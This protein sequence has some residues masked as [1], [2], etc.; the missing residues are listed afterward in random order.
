[1]SAKHAAPSHHFSIDLHI[2]TNRGSADSELTPADLIERAREL[3][4]DAVCITEHDAM[5]D[6]G[7]IARI[8]AAAGVSVLRGMEVTTEAG[9]VGAFG[10]EGYTAGIYKLGELRRIADRQGAILI[11][12]HPFRYKLDARMAFLDDRPFDLTHPERA[13]ELEIFR[14]V[15]AIE[16]LN[17]ACSEEEN[18]FALAVARHLGLAEV[19]G[20]DSHS[21]ASVGCVATLLPGPVR[22]ERELLGAIRSRR[23]GAWR[24]PVH[25]LS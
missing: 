17:G 20:S 9:H 3:G 18:R 15:D 1:M 7:E 13:A 8:A 24:R 6:V 14:M 19:A 23:C 11:A 10:L 16:V 22:S 2:H 12:N 25:R 21:A 4:I 5:W